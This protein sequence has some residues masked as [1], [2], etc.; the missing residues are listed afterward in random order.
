MVRMHTI[1]LV[2]TLTL[3][4]GPHDVISM[5]HIETSPLSAT[6][7]RGLAIERTWH[8]REE[9]VSAQ[10]NTEALTI[11]QIIAIE[12]YGDPAKGIHVRRDSTPEKMGFRAGV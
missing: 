8:P 4:P 7:P 2:L 12:R 9:T 3:L 10:E 1:Y 6:G 5:Y 11:G